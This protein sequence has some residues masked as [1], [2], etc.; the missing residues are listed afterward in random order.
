MKLFN[1]KSP[2]EANTIGDILML[3]SDTK[4]FNDVLFG[5]FTDK[6]GFYLGNKSMTIDKKT[7]NK[8]INWYQRKQLL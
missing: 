7:F 4:K 1:F 2:K 6:V 3:Q 8:I 5:V